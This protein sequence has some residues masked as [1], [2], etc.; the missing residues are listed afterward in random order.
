MVDKMV[1]IENLNKY[2]SYIHRLKMEMN[3][4]ELKRGYWLELYCSCNGI[5]GLKKNIG[6]AMALIHNEFPDV[7]KLSRNG[8]VK[9]INENC[10]LGKLVTGAN[11]PNKAK[12]MD[13]IWPYSLGGISED[14]NRA[15]LCEYCNRGK[16]NA[17]VG[18]FPWDLETPEWV[19]ERI[20]LIRR[21]IGN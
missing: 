9:T 21:R 6:T 13:H 18:Y 1:G 12:E 4:D 8:F 3:N 19:L 2:L 15:D 17:I 20:E 14:R 5:D 16:S 11:C 7:Q 10:E